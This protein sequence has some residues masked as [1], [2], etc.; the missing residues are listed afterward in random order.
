MEPLPIPKVTLAGRICITGHSTSC[1]VVAA[2]IAL[3]LLLYNARQ[4]RQ[5]KHMQGCFIFLEAVAGG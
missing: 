1:S 3:T 2:A 4:E 5:V